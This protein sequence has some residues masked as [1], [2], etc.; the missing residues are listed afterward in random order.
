MR[1]PLR[2]IPIALT[3]LSLFVLNTAATAAPIFSTSIVADAGDVAN[4]GGTVLAARNLGGGPNAGTATINGISFDDQAFGEAGVFSSSNWAASPSDID[5]TDKFSGD[6]QKLLGSLIFDP[7]A[8]GTQDSTLTFENLVVGIAYDLQLFMHN[9]I[10]ATGINVRV[11]HDASSTSLI[12]SNPQGTALKIGV[13]FVADASSFALRFDNTS[14]S[15]P[16]RHILNGFVLQTAAVPEPGT[17]GLLGAALFMVGAVRR[18]SV[19]S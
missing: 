19:A 6:L 14:D 18:A 9:D 2:F 17:L 13:S 1:L 3:A 4:F 10:N 15:E 5:P 16:D 12:T 8:G 11:F 7:A